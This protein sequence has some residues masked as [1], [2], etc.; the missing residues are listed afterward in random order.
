MPHCTDITSNNMQHCT[1]IVEIITL[2]GTQGSIYG[3]KWNKKPAIVKKFIDQTFA[4]ELEIQIWNVLKDFKN[5]HFCKIYDTGENYIV[6][7]QIAFEKTLLSISD[8]FYE[9]KYTT[10]LALNCIFQT[11]AAVIMYEKKNITHYDLHGDNVLIQKTPYDIHVYKIDN[12]FMAIETFGMTPVIIDF[13]LSYLNNFNYLSTFSFL[14]YGYTTFLQDTNIDSRILLFTC[15]KDG[16]KRKDKTF[17]HFNN[18]TRLIFS[19]LD[20]SEETG[21][22]KKV[23]Y[24]DLIKEITEELALDE[25]GLFS[26]ENIYWTLDAFHSGIVLPMTEV[27]SVGSFFEL[28]I[29]FSKT[30]KKYIITDIQTQKCLLKKIILSQ[31]FEEIESFAPLFSFVK[32]DILYDLKKQTRCLADSLQQLFISNNIQTIQHSLYSK[33]KYPSTQDILFKLFGDFKSRIQ[34]KPYHTLYLVNVNTGRSKKLN[35]TATLADGLNNNENDMFK[36]FFSSF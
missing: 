27:S 14:N 6:F 8:I 22:L 23:H 35:L 36:T 9:K 3:C 4:F 5:I 32:K 18:K 12:F 7:K 24:P 34:Y 26:Q 11:L 15:L 30:W 2:Q 29:V 28:Y 31:T 21:R 16:N 20:V 17:C 13:G 25:T 1:D 19:Q 33:L 10:S